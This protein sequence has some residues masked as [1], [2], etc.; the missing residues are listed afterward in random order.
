[1]SSLSLMCAVLSLPLA[2]SA[3]E[4]RP[5]IADV[6]VTDMAVEIELEFA[7]EG[8]LS[9]IDLGSV[10]DTNEAPQADRYDALR[11]QKPDAL[12]AAF[13]A[14]WPDLAPGL[15]LKVGD[16]NLIADIVTMNVPEV[17]DVEL[18][19]DSRMVVLAVLPEGEQGVQVGWLPEYG[20]LIVRQSG[21]G[22][23]LYAGYLPAGEL[24]DTLPRTGIAEINKLTAFVTYTIIG[25][26][27]IIPKGMDHILFV[28]AL[29]MF[30]LKLRPLII[31]ISAFT[32]AHTLTLALATLDYVSVSPQIVEPL[33]AASI[34]YAAVENLFGGSIGARRVVLIVLFGL[35][36]GLGFAS[37]LGEI[38]LERSNLVISLVAFNIG[39]EIGQLAVIACAFATIYVASAFANRRRYENEE[40]AVQNRAVLF[41]GAS[42]VGSLLIAAIGILWVIERTLF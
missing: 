7:A 42:M 1:M 17:G 38:G 9:G 20:P 11:Q 6:L 24:S 30:A 10:S 18:P 8:L 2:A 28:L 27:H 25:I 35:L 36:H 19:R 14:A 40:L 39:V 41:R 5:A 23:D 31:Q 15:I 26:E 22:D 29:F 33:I 34:V 21:A 4:V 12:E 32:L 37:V 13:R 16:T 3:H